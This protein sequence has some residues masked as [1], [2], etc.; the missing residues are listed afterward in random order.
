MSEI[1]EYDLIIVGGGPGGIIG[2]HYALQAGLLVIVLEREPVVGG[3]WA[4]LPAWQDIQNR[5]EDWT[6]GDLPIG[7]EYQPAIVANINAWVDTF[8]LAPHIRVNCPVLSATYADGGWSVQTPDGVL[9]SKALISATGVHNEPRVPTVRRNNSTVREFHSSTLRDPTLLGGKTVVV[10]GG[11]ASA[12]DLVDLCIEHRAARVVWVH[13]SLKWMVPTRKAKRFASNV[14][15]LAKAHFNG[16]SVP[17]LSTALDLDLRNRY[18]KFGIEELLPVAPF[19]L[20]RDQLIPGRRR[21]IEGFRQ[22]E[23]HNSEIDSIDGTLVR[24]QS[25]VTVGADIVLWGTGY[26]MNLAY[27]HGAGLDGIECP[28]DLAR[29]C[30]SLVVSLDAPELYFLSVGLESTSSTPWHYAH[31]ARTIVSQI[32][33]MAH[34]GREPVTKH[35]NYYGVPTFLAQYDP[36]NYPADS[37]HDRY[38]AYFNDYP[39]DRPLPIPEF[40]TKLFR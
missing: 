20:N 23:R 18:L 9:R 12:F 5:A 35:L 19:D 13:R 37:W 3:L 17:A 24:L 38:M 27:L 6:L 32:C 28:H 26:S 22:V 2:L 1:S 29:R 4:R 39:M 40:A 11:G 21:L 25:D 30:G 16:E 31:L 14:R 33:G 10:V 8:A 34:F 15:E 7:D 36:I